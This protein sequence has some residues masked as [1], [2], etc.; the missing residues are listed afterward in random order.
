MVIFMLPFRNSPASGSES[1]RAAENAMARLQGQTVIRTMVFGDKVGEK[2]GLNLKVLRR[3]VDH[4][5]DA[6][7]KCKVGRD[8]V[9]PCERI[10]GRE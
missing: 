6:F 2:T 5:A 8:G 4:C 7:T 9:T 10:R 1:N 3:L